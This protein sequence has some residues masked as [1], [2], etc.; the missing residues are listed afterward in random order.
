MNKCERNEATFSV[1]QLNR[2]VNFSELLDL[3]SYPQLDDEIQEI[4]VSPKSSF[5]TIT[6]PLDAILAHMFTISEISLVSYRT[7]LSGEE[8]QKDLGA[9]IEQMQRISVH[10]EPPTSSRMSSLGNRARRVLSNVLQVHIARECIKS[11]DWQVNH[12]ELNFSATWTSPQWDIIRTDR[13]GVAEGALDRNAKSEPVAR[14]NHTVLHKLRFSGYLLQSKHIVQGKD[15]ISSH[16]KSSQRFKCIEWSIGSVSSP[17]RHIRCK[18]SFILLSHCW[19]PQRW[20]AIEFRQ[21][22]FMDH[23]NAIGPSNIIDL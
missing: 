5:A 11:R 21:H 15:Q 23:P 1:F 19:T 7:E 20:M 14:E 3:Q 8:T 12:F 13:I 17:I 10:T 18:S 22:Y 2:L 6:E 16:W 9:F 4:F